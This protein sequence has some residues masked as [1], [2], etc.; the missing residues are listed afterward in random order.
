MKKLIQI[1]SLLS[2]LIVFSVVSAKAQ[3][4]QRFKADIPFCV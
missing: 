3:T 1:C 2:L 4:I